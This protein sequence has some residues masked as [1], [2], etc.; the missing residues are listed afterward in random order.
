MQQLL[1]CMQL[2]HLMLLV[3]FCHL[4]DCNNSAL[5]TSCAAKA[6]AAAA[7]TVSCSMLLLLLRSTQY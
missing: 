6:A 1:P 2:P 5:V 3:L 4:F 7:A